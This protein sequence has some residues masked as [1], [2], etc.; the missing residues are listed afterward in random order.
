MIKLILL[1]KR[2]AGTTPEAFRQHY[3]GVHAP[4]VARLLSQWLVGYTRN[5][6]SALPDGREPACDCVTEFLFRDREALQA[7]LAWVRTE[8]GQALALDEE[9]FMDRSSMRVALADAASTAL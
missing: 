9:N 5:H 7:C 3:E 4:L 2:K 1:V 6:L 8:D